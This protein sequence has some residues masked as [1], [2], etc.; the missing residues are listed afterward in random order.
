MKR[1]IYVSTC[2]F[3]FPFLLGLFSLPHIAYGQAEPAKLPIGQ[4]CTDNDNCSTD[5]CEENYLD[6]KKYC[7]CSAAAI[8]S[9][10][11]QECAQ[12]YGTPGQDPTK[13]ECND[14]KITT[15]NLNYCQY[16][17]E[18][19]EQQTKLSIGQICTDDND[20]STDVCEKSAIDQR[21]YCVCSAAAVGSTGK[22][23]CSQAY[24]T[25]GQDPT[26]WECNDGTCGSGNLN[27]CQYDNQ[28]NSKFPGPVTESC[29]LDILTDTS[30]AIQLNAAAL[31]KLIQAP[32]LKITI[33]GVSF[34]N[35]SKLKRTTDERGA[36]YV[37]FPYLGE[38]I[39]SIY[40]YG[41][42]A[43]G[44]ASV[45]MIMYAGL[46]WIASSG[47]SDKIT[48]AKKHITQAIIGLFIATTSYA[49]LYLINPELVNFRNL[50][51][52][53]VQSIPLSEHSAEE[54]TAS[55]V[56]TPCV[57]RK[58]ASQ[59]LG[60][61][62][63]QFDALDAFS[64]GNRSLKSVRY[65]ILHEGSRDKLVNGI[66]ATVNTLKSRQLSTH[67]VVKRDGTI[68]EAVDIRRRAYHAGT[69]NPFSIGIDLSI[70]DECSTGTACVRDATCSAKCTYTQEQYD[71]INKI[72]SKV[73]PMTS[74]S[75]TDGSILNHCQVDN[76]RADARNFDYSKIGLDSTVHGCKNKQWSEKIATQLAQ[77]DYSLKKA[78]NAKGCCEI[79]NDT[80]KTEYIE[81]ET[82]KDCF[83]RVN[84]VM[85]QEST[86]PNVSSQSVEEE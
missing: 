24:G 22:E 59:S 61:G 50:R 27:Y 79:S 26:K 9:T 11:D 12:A 14:G 4:I 16:N 8:G 21:N 45:V 38:Y 68:I 56:S 66:D 32:S 19:A 28:V 18:A 78:D 70:A 37:Y 25:P 5:V 43:I 48:T 3:V 41:I 67:F 49:L 54:E 69:I 40:K 74:I 46:L 85:W 57:G 83:N 47:Q 33:P 35:P 17:D 23:D 63:A 2:L 44:V 34:T 71:A 30:A 1:R 64:C 51:V 84:A 60:L 86:C 75:R 29:G 7:V 36:T 58:P 13:W 42:I 65:I 6:G 15:G 62:I 20:C 39:A 55:T 82:N 31:N 81:S 52:M 76:N 10:G 73:V 72:I 53:I 80:G 77:Q